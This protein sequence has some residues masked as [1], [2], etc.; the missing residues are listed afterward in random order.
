MKISLARL[1]ARYVDLSV[2]HPWALTG[3]YLLITVLLG[4]FAFHLGLSTSLS[5]LLPPDTP[6]VRAVREASA[7]V[8][9]TDMLIIAI[10]TQDTRLGQKAADMVA[11]DMRRTMPD[12]SEVISR[13]D[14]SF[15]RKNSLLYFSISDLRAIDRQLK[16]V[17]GRLKLQGMGLIELPD[18]DPEERRLRDMIRDAGLRALRRV[19]P[20]QRSSGAQDGTAADGQ[21]PKAG[22]LASRDGRVFAVV[23]RPSGKSVD[24]K[25]ARSLVSRAR[26]SIRRVLSRLGHPDGLKME[27]GGGFRNRV[28]EYESIKK[29]A[30]SSFAL[31]FLLMAL[32]VSL[33]FRS[34]RPLAVVFPPLVMA[35]IWTLGLVRLAGVERLNLITAFIGAILL[36]MGIDYGVHLTARFMEEA[37]LTRDVREALHRTMPPTTRA[38]GAAALTTSVALYLMYISSFRGF[39]EFG[40]IAGTGILVALLA[41][42]L[43]FPPVAVLV[44]LSGIARRPTG[45]DVMPPKRLAVALLSASAIAVIAGALLW[46]PRLSFETNMRALSGH[47]STSI[48]YGRAVGDTASPTVVLCSDVRSCRAVT[49]GLEKRFFT[50]LPDPD[51]KG[52]LSPHLFVPQNQKEKLAVI[53]SMSKRLKK[54][55][56][57]VKKDKKGKISNYFKYLPKKAISFTDLPAWVKDRFTERSGLIGSFLY[58]YSARDTWDVGQ[59]RAFKDSFRPADMGAPGAV[60]ASSSFILVDVLD[61][62]VGDGTRIFL[63]ALLLVFAVVLVTMRSLGGAA[64][65]FG[66][67]VTG[68]VLGASLM[69]WLGQHLGI[70]NMVVVS[71]VVGTGIDGAVH[72]YHALTEEGIPFSRA[73]FRTAPAI[74]VAALTTMAGFGTM[75]LTH[76]GGLS[77]I[78]RLAVIGI[79]ATLLGSLVVVPPAVQLFR[80]Q[81]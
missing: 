46:L 81:S 57:W 69:P 53:S 40:L 24:M 71:T 60:V 6:S 74:S 7:R 75:M 55:R 38:L 73:L 16:K 51:I 65:I 14:L 17:V 79:G 68:L 34:V 61:A 67:L 4:W 15:F 23:A 32:I 28:K 62:A 10:S 33:Y 50:D 18:P 58:I 8:G 47:P 19:I 3:V 77:S 9:S 44:G 70:Y 64:V 1:L 39:W 80:K 11:D 43:V 2:H 5:Q 42:V 13:L 26:A 37:G 48:K 29:D 36:G 72:L 76:H 12:L 63:W 27:V 25:Y 20:V 35:I 45:Y 52:F 54:A 78:G 56:R 66:A 31:S 49:Q 59:A 21:R 41:Y 30:T 22:Y